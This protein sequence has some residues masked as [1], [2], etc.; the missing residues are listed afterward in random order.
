MR[1]SFFAVAVA[2]FFLPCIGGLSFGRSGGGGNN[3]PRVQICQN[4]HCCQQWPHQQDLPNTLLDL[5]PPDVDVDIE[6]TGCLSE[7]GKGP[8]M[9]FLLH[10]KDRSSV[11]LHAMNGPM[12]V[13]GELEDH[14][15][16]RVPSK[17]VAA[18]TV[19][20][21]ASKGMSGTCLF[22]LYF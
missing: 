10:K 5:L 20:D 19:M 9:I 7:C 22:V 21:K 12:H 3:N 17:L 1:L 13:A 6:V 16:I 11:L 18:V 4:K 15:G 2:V 8:N 14:F